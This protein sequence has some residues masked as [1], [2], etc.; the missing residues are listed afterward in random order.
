MRTRLV[1]LGFMVA[2]AFS[3][4]NDVHA[5]QE[6]RLGAVEKSAPQLDV[7]YAMWPRVGMFG[8]TELMIAALEMNREEVKRLVE[9]GAN[10]EE[11]DD[12]GGTPLMWAVQGGDIEIVNFLLDNGADVG[13]VGGRNATAL[14]I[15]VIAGKED[16]GVRLLEAGATFGGELSYQ[17]DYLEYTAAHGQAHM[18]RALL[19]YGANLNE[20]GSDAL[21]FAIKNRHIEVAKV[22]IEAGTDVNQRGNLGNDLPIIHAL[23]TH[24]QAMVQLLVENGAEL[25]RKDRADR[26]SILY[27]GVQTGQPSIVAYL[28]DNGAVFGEQ[29]GDQ[30]LSSAV[31]KGSM[32]MVDL[33]VDRGATISPKLLFSAIS[34][35]HY[36]MSDIFANA[37][38]IESMDDHSLDRLLDHAEKSGYQAMVSELLDVIDSREKYGHLRLLFESVEADRCRLNTWDPQARAI[39]ATGLDDLPCDAKLFTSRRHS[40]LFVQQD[41][42]INVHSLDNAF[43][44]FSLKMPTREIEARLDDIRAQFARQYA[45]NHDWVSAQIATIGYLDNGQIT[46][47]THTGGPAD[48]TYASQFAWDGDVWSLVN[49]QGCHRFDWICHMPGVDGRSIDRWPMRGAVWHAALRRNPGFV[50]RIDQGAV[51]FSFDGRRSELGYTLSG[52]DHCAEECTFTDS[53]TIN[54]DSADAIQIGLANSRVSIADQFVLVRPAKEQSRLYDLATGDD[55]LGSIGRATWIH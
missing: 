55:V 39:T 8:I 12:T 16:I 24:D 37:I 5:Q 1:F 4:G 28:L 30:L 40:T 43:P 18:V 41:E 17:Q 44:T 45:G 38:G 27:Y 14:M 35:K 42:V 25:N 7:G 51:I 49:T 31:Y 52:S 34:N 20:S 29:E 23:Q 3:V 2:A 10:I 9:Q 19:Q 11:R 15:A 33:F 13:A 22:L 54:P 50:E 6:N 21:C 26:A 48:G 46:V 32:D 53:V 36:E 47:I